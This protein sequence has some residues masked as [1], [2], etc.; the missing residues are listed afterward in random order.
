MIVINIEMWPMGDKEQSYSLGRMFIWN[1][2]TAHSK[3]N[4]KRGDYGFQILRKNKIDRETVDTTCKDEVA[5][6]EVNNW[7]RLSYSVWKLVSKCLSEA[8]KKG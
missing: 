3:S 2:G 8:F 5:H 6:G 1:K 7:P 4:G